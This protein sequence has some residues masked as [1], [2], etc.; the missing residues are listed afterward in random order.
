MFTGT[1][2]YK[3]T[4]KACITVVLTLIFI[5]KSVSKKFI[6][7]NNNYDNNDNGM[8]RFFIATKLYSYN[9]GSPAYT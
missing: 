9:F 6:D 7:S 3:S 5:V 2:M 4:K 8:R 1:Q